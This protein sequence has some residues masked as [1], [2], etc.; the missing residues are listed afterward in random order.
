MIKKDG[1]NF[2]NLTD[3]DINEM[4]TGTTIPEV[5][6]GIRARADVQT[7]TLMEANGIPIRKSI[8]NNV[9]GLPEPKENTIY[10]VSSMCL[11]ALQEAGIKRTDVVSPG[12]VTY[13]TPEEGKDFKI[14]GCEGFRCL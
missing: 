8:V 12:K 14:K 3:H 7:Y 11:S 4:I 9:T 10:I 6:R 13:F 5:K 2:V 1:V